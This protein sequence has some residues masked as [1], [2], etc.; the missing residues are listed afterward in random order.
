MKKLAVV[1]LLSTV[2]TPAFSTPGP[3]LMV[4]A[5]GTPGLTFTGSSLS[6]TINNLGVFSL[7]PVTLSTSCAL[8]HP[9]QP[10]DLLT[11]TANVSSTGAGVLS[12]ES[13]LPV[14]NNAV[15]QP[16]KFVLNFSP[17]TVT[18][19]INSVTESFTLIDSSGVQTLATR[20]FTGSAPGSV[21]VVTYNSPDATSTF[22][23]TISITTTGAAG[24]NL[25]QSSTTSVP[26]PGSLALLGA[27]VFGLLTLRRSHSR[28]QV[29]QRG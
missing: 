9:P 25:G 16:A 23:E 2:A 27:S 21:D 12:I 22:F 15:G 26:E 14:T 1:I 10:C 8:L 17:I 11:T 7:T 6:E 24:I 19:S 29:T 5:Q 20:N 13:T 3:S 18:G 28:P 4:T